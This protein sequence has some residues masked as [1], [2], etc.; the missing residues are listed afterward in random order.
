MPE[1]VDIAAL[2][3]AYTFGIAKNHGFVDGNKRAAFMTAYS[4]LGMNGKDFDATE[5]DVVSTIEGVAAGRVTE[6]E[7]AD[8]YRKGLTPV[9]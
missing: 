5:T 7:L 6:S 9:A 4:F 2:A 1:G 3:A 8:W